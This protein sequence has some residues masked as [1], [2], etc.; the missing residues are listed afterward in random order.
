MSGWQIGLIA[1]FA[2][3]AFL[4]VALIGKPRKPTTPM[5]AA[6]ILL[7]DAALIYVAVKA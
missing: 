1:W 7:L 3:G 4:Q 5:Q 6:I 2:L